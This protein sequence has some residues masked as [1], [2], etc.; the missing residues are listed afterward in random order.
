[1]IY[2]VSGHIDLT[3]EEFN[4]Y[5]A[6]EI[7][8]V[9]EKDPWA[10]FVVGDCK[11][12]DTM[13]QELLR[14]LV[15]DPKSVTVHHIG[16]TPRNLAS[17]DFNRVGGY[18]TDEERDAEMTGE[19]DQDIAFIKPGRRKSGTAKNIVRRREIIK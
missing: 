13:A 19:S 17:Q 18:K 9:L 1:M 6:P 12:V 14:Y 5:Y 4:K 8:K 15:K 3:Q 10:K 2:F 7:E 11:G 16:T